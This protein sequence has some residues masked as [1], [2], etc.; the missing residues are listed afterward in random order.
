MLTVFFNFPPLCFLNSSPL[1]FLT[2]S[3][4]FGATSVR[5]TECGFPES[6]LGF[7]FAALWPAAFLL[8]AAGQVVM[9]E[10][11]DH[12]RTSDFGARRPRVEALF[13]LRIRAREVRRSKPSRGRPKA[14][15]EDRRS[16]KTEARFGL[17]RSAR[18]GYVWRSARL[19]DRAVRPGIAAGGRRRDP[20]TRPRQVPPTVAASSG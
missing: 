7:I 10:A 15:E 17:R 4:F 18:E 20:R 14:P 12:L 16:L 1:F 11:T 5:M 19:A 2:V 3:V 8:P 9:R 13:G 6:G